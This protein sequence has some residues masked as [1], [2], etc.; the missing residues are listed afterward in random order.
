MSQPSY[1]SF[2][3]RQLIEPLRV[4]S[5]SSRKP[6]RFDLKPNAKMR[7]QIAAYLGINAVPMLRFVG[8]VSPKGRHDF[9]L[10]AVLEAQVEQACVVTLEPVLTDLREE[11]LRV[12]LAKW[13]EPEADEMEMSDDDSNEA[14]GEEIDLGHVAVEALSLALPP[15]PRAPGAKLNDAQ[16]TAPGEAPLRDGDLK[17]FAGLAAL[18]AKL[19]NPE[20]GS[21]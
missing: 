1:E 9:V 2:A 5:L 19:E 6:N 10:E 21:D 4:A 13:E 15:F 18:K 14:L 7:A 12:Y 3:P 20:N 16:F 17:P 8:T 11:V